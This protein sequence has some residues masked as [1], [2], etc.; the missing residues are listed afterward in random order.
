MELGH[1]TGLRAGTAG[2]NHNPFRVE[3]GRDLLQELLS[4]GYISE[5]TDLIRSAAGNE[6]GIITGLCNELV[7]SCA[8][9]FIS[10][11]EGRNSMVASNIWSNS[12]LPAVS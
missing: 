12:T 5:R 2:G 4:T 6:I 11:P 3:I 10:K 8:L 9:A 1:E 7:T